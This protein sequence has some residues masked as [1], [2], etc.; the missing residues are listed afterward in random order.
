MYTASYISSLAIHAFRLSR[1]FCACAPRQALDSP[2][3][4]QACLEV[5]F[6]HLLESSQYRLQTFDRVQETRKGQRDRA[7]VT[8]ELVSQEKFH[9]GYALSLLLC[10]S[11]L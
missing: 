8:V 6:P 11:G 1:S 9:Y 4:Q 5:M 3:E 10:K 2:V 7:F